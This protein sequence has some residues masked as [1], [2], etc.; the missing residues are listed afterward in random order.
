MNISARAWRAKAAPAGNLNEEHGTAQ[1]PPARTT[2]C[3]QKQRPQEPSDLASARL[4]P[5]SGRVDLFQ[6]RGAISAAPMLVHGPAAMWS[7]RSM[8]RCGRCSVPRCD[9]ETS[10]TDPNLHRDSNQRTH[11][12]ISRSLDDAE[13]DARTAKRRGY[14]TGTYQSWSL[15][16]WC[17]NLTHYGY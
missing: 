4:R 6:P 2:A 10:F 9:E 11:Q 8:R 13:P 15:H 12:T 3:R 14:H 17:P 7:M 16:L 5:C 1:S